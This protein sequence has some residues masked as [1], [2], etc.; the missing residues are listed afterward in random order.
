MTVKTPK[1]KSTKRRKGKK[2]PS[3]I[4]RAMENGDQIIDVLRYPFHHLTRSGLVIIGIGLLLIPVMP[5]HYWGT[6]ALLLVGGVLIIALSF[7]ENHT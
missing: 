1:V 2:S 5:E 7:G 4:D 6:V 3:W